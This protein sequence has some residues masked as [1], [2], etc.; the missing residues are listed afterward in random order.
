MARAHALTNQQTK[1][2]TSHTHTEPID[3]ARSHALVLS[4]PA[5]ARDA[6]G[7]E[8]EEEEAQVDGLLELLAPVLLVVVLCPCVYVGCGL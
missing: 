3:V 8:G 5:H 2:N 4:H 7:G 6:A 1:K